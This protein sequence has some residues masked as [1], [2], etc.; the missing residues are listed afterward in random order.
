M[1]SNKDY[2]KL[3]EILEN[4]TGCKGQQ[5]RLKG[6][7][8]KLAGVREKP[9]NRQELRERADWQ[10]VNEPDEYGPL[11]YAGI[12]TAGKAR[13]ERNKAKARE[14]NSEGY[15]PYGLRSRATTPE[16]TS[17]EVDDRGWLPTKDD[18]EITSRVTEMANYKQ[19]KPSVAG[20]DELTRRLGYRR[21]R[22]G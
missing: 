12:G 4:R 3:W 1:S 2:D 21:S 13:Y 22:V 14:G 10:Y 8:I 16:P 7:Y 19:R 15:G 17:I 6:L 5:R 20:L 18:D 11:A 9:D